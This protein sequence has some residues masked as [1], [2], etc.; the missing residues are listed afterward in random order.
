VAR[1]LR[2]LN[3]TGWRLLED[4]RW[5][6]TKKA[7]V[8]LLIVGPGGVYVIDVKGWKEPRVE[9][10]RLYRGEAE[11][12]S[13]VHNILRVTELAQEALLELGVSPIAVVPVMA[14]AGH[15]IEQPLGQIQLVGE[16]NLLHWLTRRWRR[17]DDDQIAEVF[18]ALDRTFVSYEVAA[19]PFAPAVQTRKPVLPRDDAPGAA[20]VYENATISLDLDE[21]GQSLVEAELSAPIESWMTFLHPDQVRLVRRSLNGPARLRGPAGTGK[22]VVA[23]HRAAYLAS[24]RPGR[25]LFT[26]YVKSLPQ[27]MNGLFGRLAPEARDR[28][29]FRGLHSWAYR[30]LESRGIPFTLDPRKSDRA[31]NAAWTEHREQSLFSA[32]KAAK[33]YWRDEIDHVI[34]GR[35]LTQ[36]ED[37]AA[38][39]RV[40]RRRPLVEAQRK[41]VW[42]LYESYFRKLSELG[43]HDFNDLLSMALDDVRSHPLDEPYAS[44]I[45]DEVQD[46]T[47]LGVQL[48]HAL[49][50]DAAD[51]LLL[52][53]DGQQSV[54]PGGFTLV[55]AG[56][57]VTGRSTVL[58]T[59]YRNTREILAAASAVVSMDAFDEIEGTSELGR[60]DGQVVRS[61]GRVTEVLADNAASH[62]IAFVEA[63]RQLANAREVSLGDVAVLCARVRDA[64]AYGELLDGHKFKTVDLQK[65]DGISSERIKVGTFKRA[66]GLEFKVVFIPLIDQCLPVQ[67]DGESA[68]T[69]AERLSLSRRELFVGM[70]RARDHLWLGRH[71]RDD[72]Q[73]KLKT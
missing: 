44:V 8:D 4:R 23:L 24:T 59:N 40:G 16:H 58:T 13:D 20:D 49:V 56:I 43:A 55:E 3:H 57:N 68:E 28:V 32:D 70:S 18:A 21:L 66:K 63:I 1:T 53:G 19:S 42:D 47:L 39:V 36:F 5:P 48:M 60:R 73:S 62:D 12:D 52:V 15:V 61:G 7:N 71:H 38:L 34:K 35:G 30:H 50:G 37:Y 72:V 64:K 41:A 14:F 69:F 17:M 9:N 26:A 2:T 10:G 54:Y 33:D 65:Y 25:V 11:A 67:A 51:G 45:V 22:S 27:V 46:L 29:E 31:W 6:G